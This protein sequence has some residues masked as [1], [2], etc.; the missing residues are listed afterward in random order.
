MKPKFQEVNTLKKA[1]LAALLMIV[2][3]VSF[4]GFII[5]NIWLAYSYRAINNRNMFFPLLLGYGLAVVVIYFLF[6]T[7]QDPH[8]LCWDIAFQKN[9]SKVIFYFLTVSLCIM[10]GE[11]AMG[12]FVEKVMGFVWW[13][14]TRLPLNITKYTSVPT[15]VAFATGISLF[16]GFIFTPLYEIFT[17]K[18]KKWFRVLAYSFFFLMVAD[19]CHSTVYMCQHHTTFKLWEY[20]W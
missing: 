9:V 14:Y 16:M 11:W 12:T 20:V 3:L 7:P 17:Q 19:F 5:E 13:D 2:T 18:S 8:L 10:V 15:T 4:L 6:G 1:K